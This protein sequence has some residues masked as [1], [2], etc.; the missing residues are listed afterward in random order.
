MEKLH[1]A[2]VDVGFQCDRADFLVAYGKA[3]EKYRLIRYG[4]LREITNAVW[5]SETLQSLGYDLGYEDPRMK[6]ALNMFFQD[7]IDSLE[8]RPFAEVFLKKTA[9]RYKTGLVSNFTYGPVV[10]N[11]LC[12]LGINRYFNAVVV[13][14]E[15]GWR[16]P[17]RNI[18]ED[19]LTR[20]G[21][22]AEEAV[23][24]G[25]CPMED[26]KG[27][28][29]VGMKTVFVQSQF[30]DSQDLIKSGQK[31]THIA[32]DLEQICNEYTKFISD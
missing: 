5:V 6:T 28:L 25:D 20:L 24:I 11:S 2:L 18:F 27:A 7:Y 31:P 16:K 32:S 9:Q 10:H 3:H 21:V 1:E 15:N 12:R 22:A 13:S 8:L 23:F 30:Y 19:V 14:G 26:I 4:I 17:H 29:D